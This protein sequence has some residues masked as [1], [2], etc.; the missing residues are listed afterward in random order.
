[1][2]VP[3][4][5]CGDELTAGDRG[6]LS[7]AAVRV[8]DGLCSRPETVGALGDE[9]DGVIL[10]LHEDQIALTGFQAKIRSAGLDPLGVVV[11]EAGE[12]TGDPERLV[13][14]LEGARARVSLFP[15]S[16]AAHSKPVFPTRMTRR[17]RS[18]PTF[19]RRPWI[20]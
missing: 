1:M 16:S 5:M 12:Y 11:L 8:V 2:T 17:S 20:R 15:G 9:A 6:L 3:V 14:A 13:V 10:V 7:R 18:P 19:R 4:L